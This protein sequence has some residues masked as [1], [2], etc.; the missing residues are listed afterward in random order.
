MRENRLVL[1]K[2]RIAHRVRPQWNPLKRVPLIKAGFPQ[3]PARAGSPPEADKSAM[4]RQAHGG[5]QPAN[6]LDLKLNF[7]IID[8]L[9]RIPSTI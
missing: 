9:K 1:S 8:L 4:L 6:F 2:Y 5:K 7:G 3:G